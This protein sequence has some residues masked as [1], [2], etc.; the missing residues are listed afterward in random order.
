MGKSDVLFERM[1]HLLAI[2]LGHSD[3]LCVNTDNVL[4]IKFSDY[5]KSQLHQSMVKLFNRNI[6]DYKKA[7]DYI[8]GDTRKEKYASKV[9]SF[10]YLDMLN[11]LRNNK[12]NVRL[13]LKTDVY[14]PSKR[15]TVYTYEA[16]KSRLYE[17]ATC[18]LPDFES[19]LL[20]VEQHPEIASVID[21]FTDKESILDRLDSF[22]II[23]I[24]ENYKTGK[25]LEW[26]VPDGI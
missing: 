4:V 1:D 9:L 20:Y 17:L 10:F 16:H 19:A 7:L 14:F 12:N 13:E 21:Y 15:K 22:C 24:L 8:E 5:V 25:I 23:N 11:F 3:N 2:S 18:N 6:F 26:E